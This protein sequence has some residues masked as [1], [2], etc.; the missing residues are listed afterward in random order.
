[1]ASEQPVERRPK[2]IDLNLLPPEYLPR[3]ISK[4]TIGLVILV[5]VALA[6]PWPFVYLRSG[7]RADTAPLETQLA[8]LEAQEAQWI[9]KGP[10]AA[11]LKADI[12]AAEALLAT[13]EQ[14]Y[15]TFEDGLVLWS[16]I[17][18]DI[19]EAR[20]GKRI[21]VLEIEQR[22]S[23]VTIDGTATKRAYVYD[24]AQNLE[25]TERFVIPVNIKS[26]EDTGSFIEFEI[27]AYLSP[28]GGQ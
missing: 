27:V 4:V 5:I 16:E 14:D 13:I 21:T 24:Y 18:D 11:Q 20:P 1:M 7:V 17:I 12:A 8:Q 10:E 19:D 22:G 6:L 28:G 15:E 9:A 2:L 26:M 3:K 25:E 23:Q